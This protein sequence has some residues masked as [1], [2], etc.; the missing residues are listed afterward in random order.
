MKRLPVLLMVYFIIQL[1]NYLAEYNALQK[2]M[3]A[4]WFLQN[5]FQWI[6]L[7]KKTTGS[8]YLKCLR[9]NMKIWTFDSN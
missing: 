9:K 8:I 3:I 1:L 2:M 5:D 7:L 4:D 6:C